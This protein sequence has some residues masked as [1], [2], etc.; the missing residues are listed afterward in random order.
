[1]S[2]YR[3]TQATKIRRSVEHLVEAYS[4]P[5]EFQT[6]QDY[7][8]ALTEGLDNLTKATGQEPPEKHDVWN[9]S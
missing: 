7:L 1:M 3:G 8:A 4:T 5:T 9:N 2:T 6:P